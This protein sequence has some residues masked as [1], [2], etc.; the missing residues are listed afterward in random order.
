MT[1]TKIRLGIIG[2]GSGSMIGDI[3]R[4]S[5]LHTGKFELVAGALS[6]SKVRADASATAA[7]IPLDRSYGHY[8]DM[9]RAEAARTDGVEAVA[10]LTP[11]A[12]HAP[13]AQAFLE[14]GVHIICEKPMTGTLPQ[15]DALVDAV[16]AAN[17][18][19]I[20]THSYTAFAM[21]RRAREL[22]RAGELGELRTIH[23][24]YLQAGRIAY[25]Q[26]PNARNWHLDPAMSGIAGSLGDVGSHAF[27]MM[28]W[29][30]GLT[31][32]SL[33]AD[34]SAFGLHNKLDNDGTV[35]LRF[36]G[37]AKGNLTYSQMAIG[38]D[39]GFSFYLY[40]SKGGLAW[41]VEQPNELRFTR[42]GKATEILTPDADELAQDAHWEK[43]GFGP[44]APYASAFTRLY[45]DAASQINA[46]KSGITPP[47][48]LA[49][50]L[51]EGHTVMRFI[52]AS[53][54]SSAS[55]SSWMHL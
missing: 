26:D 16:N 41:S 7:G 36:K 24:A 14:H 31:V 27:H 43:T 34:L 21:V 39:N 3:H 4:L 37:G 11:N 17:V 12:L 30:T 15:A 5:A 2:G 6:S 46:R 53:V 52:E 32:E 25:D 38:K 42:A 1:S 33:A 47:A 35:L 51:A 40:G 8:E 19:F 55:G 49:P 13:V 44:F 23:S 29:L 50:G 10:I 22:I 28:T 54:K 48:M 45:E 9:A 20:L 18:A